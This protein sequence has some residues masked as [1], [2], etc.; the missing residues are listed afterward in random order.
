VLADATRARC[1]YTGA[2]LAPDEVGDVHL[3]TPQL[4]LGAIVLA[5][6]AAACTRGETDEA[7]RRTAGEVR[8]AAAVARDRLADG[9]L[10]TKVQAQYFADEDVKARYI[11]VSADEGVITLRGR[12]DSDTSREQAVQIAKNTDGVRE[13]RDLLRV[14]AAADANAA[15]HD[16]TWLTTQIQARYFADSVV[17]GDVDVAAQS[18][19]VTLSGRV[20]SEREKAQAVAIARDVDGVARVEDRLVVDSSASTAAVATSGTSATAPAAPVPIDDSRV[21]TSI[22]AKYFLDN[23]LKTRRLEVDTQQGVVTLRGEVASDDERAQAL[24]L[25]RTTEGATRV[26]D[27]LTVNAALAPMAGTSPAPAAT[28]T[29][30]ER[31]AP[32][33][34]QDASLTRSVQSRLAEDRQARGATVEVTAKDGV[35]LLDGTAPTAAAKQS[36][37]TIARETQGVVQVIDRIRIGRAR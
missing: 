25:A 2:L 8:D 32:A 19:V 16:D 35:V 33:Q 14:G 26:E 27:H 6:A 9:W 24:L 37:I 1:C 29:T 18:G 21:S 15:P 7:A 36:A 30:P 31:T 20:A 34:T 12:V 28:P 13:V 22:R 11:D 17:D 4:V 3:K 23:T 10:A 5:A